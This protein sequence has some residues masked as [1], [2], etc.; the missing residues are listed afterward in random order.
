MNRKGQ[1]HQT[2]Q[3]KTETES[4]LE[5][6]LIG[7]LSTSALCVVGHKR[8]E[9]QELAAHACQPITT[10]GGRHHGKFTSLKDKEEKRGDDTKKSRDN[11]CPYVSPVENGKVKNERQDESH[12]QIDEIKTLGIDGHLHAD[13][14]SHSK[15]HAYKRQTTGKPE[16]VGGDDIAAD[17]SADRHLKTDKEIEGED[18]TQKREPMNVAGNI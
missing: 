4:T 7:T 9:F 12:K 17:E 6:K 13:T 14:E 18:N 2:G 3:R 1:L 15:E 16:P 5:G 8:K 11:L 10:Q